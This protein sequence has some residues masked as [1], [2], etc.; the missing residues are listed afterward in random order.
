[1]EYATMPYTGSVAELFEDRFGIRG[2][3][4]ENNKPLK[5]YINEYLHEIQWYIEDMRKNYLKYVGKMGLED[6]WQ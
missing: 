6:G 5:D 1:M 4:E 2:V 3:E